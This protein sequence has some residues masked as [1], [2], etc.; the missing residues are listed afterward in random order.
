MCTAEAKNCLQNM[1]A[2]TFSRAPR[3][4]GGISIETYLAGTG[5]DIASMVDNKQLKCTTTLPLI[6]IYNLGK[7]R[8][9]DKFFRAFAT[10]I[11]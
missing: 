7:C 1:T 4:N 6:A 10:L 9:T 5:R 11:L 2:E 8:L 3:Y